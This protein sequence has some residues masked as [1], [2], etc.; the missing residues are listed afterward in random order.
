MYKAV[1]YNKYTD[2]LHIWGDGKHSDEGHNVIDYKQYAYI[3]DD[4]GKH[5]TIDGVKCSKTYNWSLEA[6]KMGMVFEHDVS[7]VTRTLI[8][9]YGHTDDSAVDVKTLFLD[10]EVA[11]EGKYSTPKEANN[12]VTSISYYVTGDNEY[13]CLLLDV[14]RPEDTWSDIVQITPEKSINANYITFATERQLLRYFINAYQKFGHSIITGWNVD[15]YDM[16]YLYNRLGKV[17][18]ESQANSLSPIK[19]VEVRDYNKMY[20]VN[21]AGVAIMDYLNLY[22]KFTYNESPNY[23]LDTIAKLELK[24]GKVE[25]DGDLDKLYNTDIKKFAEYNIVDVELIVSLDAKL[26]YIET[27][28]GICHKGHVAYDSLIHTSVYLDGAALTYCRRQNLVASSNKSKRDEQATGAYVHKP[29]PGRYKW[30]YDLDLTSLYPMN[31][32]TNNISPETKFAK[33]ENWNEEEYIND[34]N[35]VYHITTYRDTTITGQF[36][37]MFSKPKVSN[38]LEIKGYDKFKEFLID[39]DLSIASNGLTYTKTKQGIIPAILDMWFN[40]RNTA[41]NLRKKAEK[42]GDEDLAKYYDKQQLI[43]KIMLN[44]FYGVLLLPS[45]RFYDMANGEAVTL[46]GQSVIKWSQKM[47]NKYYN[48]NIGLPK[49]TNHVLYIDTDSLFAPLEPIYVNRFG[50][51]EDHTDPEIIANSKVLISEVQKFII[52]SYD[53]YAKVLHN[54]DKHRWDIKQELIARRAFWAGNTDSKTKQFGGIKKRYAQWIVDKEGHPK[55]EMDVKGLEVVRSSFPKAFRAFMKEILHDIL[56]DAE[57][58]DL[59]KKVRE[60]KKTVQSI[61]KFNIM[62]PTGVKD[63]TKFKTDGVGKRAKGTPVH[64]K[65]AMNHNDLM[66]LNNLTELPEIGDGDKIMWCYLKQNPYGFETM[67]LK[68][69]ENPQI[70]LD[71]VDKYIDKDEIFNS[72]LIEKLDNFWRS[73]GWNAVTTNELIGKFF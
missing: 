6:E 9:I 23:K 30:V 3:A 58:D 59:D 67:A 20:V 36:D 28:T 11:K 40:D 4:K 46:T 31:I 15:G 53:L 5:I 49:D 14:N 25:Y 19:R 24:R 48:D 57:R 8:D 70:I 35:K 71:F 51:M 29:V 10:I 65:A 41:K 39:N 22:K 33:V 56:H 63:M 27:G 21:I 72:A 69:D 52:E 47:A 1:Y 54:V 42:E 64:V 45:F 50:K 18:D 44:S 13:T 26:G 73:L 17:L 37:E 55:N 16:P 43:I 60:F 12:T 2:E 32:I 7:P 38:Q 62:M 34:R 66:A 68:S 61:D